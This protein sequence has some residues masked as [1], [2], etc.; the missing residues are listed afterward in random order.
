MIEIGETY[1]TNQ[2]FE[3]KILRELKT[4]YFLASG[5]DKKTHIFDRKGV[6]SMY[7]NLFLML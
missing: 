3:V 5:P 4:G 1:K 7:V 2:G 6:S